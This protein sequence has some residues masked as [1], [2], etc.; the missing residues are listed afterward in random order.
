MF[1]LIILSICSSCSILTQI[2]I[3]AGDCD[4]DG[5]IDDDDFQCIKNYNLR[6]RDFE[7]IKHIGEAITIVIQL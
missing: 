4:K 7:S 6:K 1:S 3:V 2:A 5:D